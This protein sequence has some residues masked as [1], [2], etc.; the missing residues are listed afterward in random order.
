[1]SGLWLKSRAA[2]PVMA[3]SP[4]LWL[5]ATRM[6]ASSAGVPS[7]SWNDISGN[8]YNPI[9]A[10]PSIR[11]KCVSNIQNGKNGVYFSGSTYF[12]IPNSKPGF[13]F[14]HSGQGTIFCVSKAGTGTNTDA[15][16]TLLSSGQNSGQKGV[17]L[18]AENRSAASALGT[19]RAR[20][21]A[22]NGSGSTFAADTNNSSFDNSFPENTTCIH[23][24]PFDLANGTAANR[25]TITK[26]ATL[27]QGNTQNGAVDTTNSTYDLHIG[28]AQGAISL[29]GYIFEL[30][31]VPS[32]VTGVNF[33]SV[34]AYLNS[35][36]GVY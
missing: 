34:I 20:L 12:S 28:S 30:I 16:Y 6:P 36:W 19:H 2:D 1:M 29:L 13:A 23:S 7:F 8:R 17:L 9:Q 24:I 18:L 3:L 11:P 25:V 5:D 21:I 14:L 15:G 22:Y 27:F 10:N 4:R 31:I 32:I 33:T 35:K 26:N